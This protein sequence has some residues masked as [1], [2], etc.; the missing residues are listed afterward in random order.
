VKDDELD[1]MLQESGA[2]RGWAATAPSLE[3]VRGRG[4]RLVR[5][6]RAL[7][8]TAAAV[9]AAAGA[10]TAARV[11]D[12]H[13]GQ[14]VVARAPERPVLEVTARAGVALPQLYSLVPDRAG[15]F[16]AVDGA[17]VHH[18]TRDGV[19]RTW[20]PIEP[21]VSGAL[22]LAV[23]ED[24]TVYVAANGPTSGVEAEPTLV[25]ATFDPGTGALAPVARLHVPSGPS[26][27]A[28][29]GDRLL[30]VTVEQG[31]GTVR[32]IDRTTGAVVATGH[33]DSAPLGPLEVDGNVA[34]IGT[35]HGLVVLDVS[36]LAVRESLAGSA[37]DAVVV[38]GRHWGITTGYELLDLDFGSTV[39]VG[40][41]RV[42][43]VQVGDG[44]LWVVTEDAL[45]VLDATGRRLA[46]LAGR[47]NPLF[48]VRGGTT[49]LQTLDETR[50]VRVALRG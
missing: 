32:S 43:S 11:V 7:G 9:V 5:R 26:S 14:S 22:Q 33:L 28:V 39:D 13:D 38:D 29:A 45:V 48:T 20:E 50:F 10:L 15:G 35:E 8:S 21:N 3:A 6:R 23:A 41:S 12:G 4:R 40:R 42:F 2:A 44:R 17:R 24:G 37:D 34:G 36:T 16:W 31:G 47:W 46:S 25:L 27:L 19:A 49:W 1:A 30:V 18:V